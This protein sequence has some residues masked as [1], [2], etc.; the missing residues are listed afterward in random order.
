[1]WFHLAT[2]SLNNQVA[3]P[4]CGHYTRTTYSFQTL[5]ALQG[6]A[7]CWIICWKS[8]EMYY[9]LHSI[10]I[11]YFIFT[12]TEQF[13]IFPWILTQL[14]FITDSLAEE[15][16]IWTFLLLM[17]KLDNCSNQV[18]FLRDEFKKLTS[19]WKICHLQHISIYCR[20]GV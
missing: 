17:K 19:N 2:S 4:N 11:S 16:E 6:N 20:A 10:W 8:W 5:W 15:T 13:K 7:C 12:L 1:M 9:R 14:E 3:S 18:I